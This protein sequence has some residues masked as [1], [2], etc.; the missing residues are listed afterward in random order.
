M[1]VCPIQL[2]EMLNGGKTIEAHKDKLGWLLDGRLKAWI[3]KKEQSPLGEGKGFCVLRKSRRE[4]EV[5]RKHKDHYQELNHGKDECRQKPKWQRWSH[6][7]KM[8]KDKE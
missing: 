5:K 8:W 1:T 6:V 4:R 7:L 2:T 3:L